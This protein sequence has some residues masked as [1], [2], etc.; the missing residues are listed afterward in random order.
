M[1]HHADPGWQ[2]L[3]PTDFPNETAP[4][5]SDRRRRDVWRARVGARINGASYQSPAGRVGWTQDTATTRRALIAGLEE[6]RPFVS[7]HVL[8]VGCGAKPYERLLGE[9][10]TTWL[11]VDLP[12]AFSGRTA[13]DVFGSALALPFADGIFD[14]VLST[15]VMEHL[16]DPTAGMREMY[17]V[18]RL[19]GHLI[20]TTPFYYGLHEEPNDYYRFTAHGLRYLAK[21]AGFSVV[22]LEPCGDVL[23]VIGQLLAYR[24]PFDRAGRVQGWVLAAVRSWIQRLCSLIDRHHHWGHDPLRYVMICAKPPTG[25]MES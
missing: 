25:T 20:A 9:R 17:R 13:A 22:L 18:L 1:Q 24:L 8:D 14:T 3:A 15:E 2:D 19:G 11:G 12:W 6:A 21:Q 4:D 7:G 10:A 5:E 23:S 16:P